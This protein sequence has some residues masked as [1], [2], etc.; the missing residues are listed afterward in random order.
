M[1]TFRTDGTLLVCAYQ[2]GVDVQSFLVPEFLL[3]H[4]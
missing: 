2:L 3:P 1:S 4:P